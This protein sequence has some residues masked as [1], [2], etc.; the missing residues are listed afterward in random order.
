[1]KP[2]QTEA[3]KRQNSEASNSQFYAQLREEL[4]PVT[5]QSLAAFDHDARFEGVLKANVVEQLLS[6]FDKDDPANF[7]KAEELAYAMGYR[8]AQFQDFFNKGLRKITTK[9]TEEVVL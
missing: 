3:E 7:S 2:Y 5:D 9:S 6:A 8:V 1:M 4:N